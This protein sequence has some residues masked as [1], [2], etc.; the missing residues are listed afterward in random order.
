MV[1][2]GR[3]TFAKAV[4]Y[5]IARV[6]GA[7][8]GAYGLMSITTGTAT[9]RASPPMHAIKADEIKGGGMAALDQSFTLLPSF[10]LRCRSPVHQ[11]ARQIRIQPC[12]S[13]PLHESQ[14]NRPNNSPRIERPDAFLGESVLPEG[15]LESSH[16]AKLPRLLHRRLCRWSA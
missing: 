9:L 15:S 10:L 2:A 8:V 14:A 5:L 3:V 4:P 12:Q 1:A 7:V 13:W 6:A 11:L 16:H